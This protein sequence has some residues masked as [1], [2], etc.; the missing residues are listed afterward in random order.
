MNEF[1]KREEMMQAVYSKT[2]S[3]TGMVG[4]ETTLKRTGEA[5]IQKSS[6]NFR[7][8]LTAAMLFGFFA[9]AGKTMGQTIIDQ[10]TCG[11][12]LTYILTSDSVLTISGSGDMT[13][14]VQGT[15][16]WSNYQFRIKTVVIGDSVTSIGDWAFYWC[17]NLDSITI[18]NGVATIGYQAFYE[19]W[20]LSSITI[21]D[22]VTS[23]GVRAFAYC[24]NLQTVNYNAINCTNMGVSYGTATAFSGDTAFR[25]LNI[26]NQVRTIPSQAFDGCSGLTSITIP[27]SIAT[28]GY[29]AFDNCRN[30]QTVNFNAINCTTTG[31]SIFNGDT[32]FVTLN[33]GNQVKTIPDYAFSWCSSLNSIAIGNSV[34]NIGD[35]AFGNCIGLTFVT[36][37]DSVASIGRNAFENCKNLQTVNFNAVNCT[38]MGSN[39]GA[40]FSGDT[41]FRTLNI[42]NQVKTIPDYAFY[43]CSGITSITIPDSIATIGYGAFW[44]CNNLQ[45]VNYNA[46]NC[47]TVGNYVFMSDTAFRIL[48]IGNQVRT[49]PSQAF[50]GCTYLTSIT[51]PDSVTSIGDYAFNNC[52][53]LHTVN[54][55][56]INCTNMGTMGRFFNGDTSFTTLNIGNQVKTIPNSAFETCSRLTSIAIPSSVTNIGE[57]AFRGCSGLDSI[58]IPNSVTSIGNYAFQDCSGLKSASMGKGIAGIILYVFRGCSR[59]TTIDV[60]SANSRYS[61]IDGIVYSK[62]QD[63]LVLCPEGRKTGT[64]II[65]N[66]VTTIGTYAFYNCDSL[67]TITIPD[68]VTSIDSRAV[69]N[70]KNLTSI[71]IHAIIP[72]MLGTDAFQNVPD[73]IPVY[74]PCLTYDKYNSAIG[75]RDFSNFVVNGH[76]DSTFYNAVKCENVPYT[77]SNFTIPIYQAGIYYTTLANSTNCDSII[78]LTLTEYPFVPITTYSDTICSGEIYSDANFTNLTKDSIYYDTL[79]NVNGC[80]S[81]IEL[82]L[83]VNSLDTTLLFDSIQQGET[84]NKN[85]FSVSEA[86]IYTQELQSVYGC[87]SVVVLHLAIM[88]VGVKQLQGTSYKL[89]VYPN[90]TSGKLQVTSYELQENSVVEIYDVVG[91]CVFTT[92][93][94][95]HPSK[96]G[97]SSTSAQFPSFGGAGVVIDVSHLS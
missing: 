36:I 29:S 59:L 70:C 16:S 17:F 93:S 67:T 1:F 20:G 4:A 77:D 58:I 60:D 47:T 34:T 86:G 56:A 96:G 11:A 49:I 43:G 84:Y 81:V 50:S 78:C 69:V 61:S 28:I 44:D 87:D 46:I 97:E 8:L 13:N 24:N 19:C 40:V 48:N 3:V 53:R 66:S 63:T 90:P 7:N 74:I 23:V 85:G 55:N 88:G 30:L 79:Q 33:I 10:G 37:P 91:Q 94:F 76:T 5:K 15:A 51:I 2:N 95:G 71:T 65:P 35:Y 41:A 62:M 64:V 83:T 52:T 12:N 82:T 73:T 18:G 75:W 32:A 72:P 25:I 9:F 26:G 38:T 27:D 6:G 31:Y 45:T 80:D 22:S 14:F 89:Q 39:Y 54:F 68:N 92:P 21:P 42:G 57:R